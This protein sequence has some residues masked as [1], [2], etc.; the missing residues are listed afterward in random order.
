MDL[1]IS[2]EQAGADIIE[3]GIPYSDPLAD[4][5]VIQRSY[6]RALKSGSSLIKTLNLVKNFRATNN[7]TPVVLMGYYNPILQIG[8]KN[9]VNKS[10]GDPLDFSHLKTCFVIFQSQWCGLLYF[11]L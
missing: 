7:D 6:I 11:T 9:F 5:P 10:N 8:L 1:V 2:M 3:L 4:G